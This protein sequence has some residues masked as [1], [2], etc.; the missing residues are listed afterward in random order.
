MQPLVPVLANEPSSV[1]E[2]PSLTITSPQTVS[3]S[4]EPSESQH[5]S[6]VE[7]SHAPA[8]EPTSMVTP[9]DTTEVDDTDADNSIMKDEADADT[10]VLATGTIAPPP[11]E[12]DIPELPFT[13]V[14]A[15][16]TLSEKLTDGSEAPTSTPIPE[17]AEA[18]TSSS[19]SSNGALVSDQLS[20]KSADSNAAGGASTTMDV[21]E[22]PTIQSEVPQTVDTEETKN[23]PG[24]DDN[25]SLTVGDID[26]A[27]TTDDRSTTTV[28][29]AP[30]VLVNSRNQANSDFV[31]TRSECVSVGNGSFYCSTPQEPTSVIGVD[32]VFSAS[33]ATGDREIFI[34]RA[35]VLDQLTLNELE[36][37][38]PYYDAQSNSIVFHRLLND[39]YQIFS[40]DL[41]TGDE[42]QLTFDRYNNMQP[43]RDGTGTV[44]QGWVGNDWEIML[45]ENDEVIMLTDNTVNDVSP[46]INGAYI[47]WQTFEN[48]GWKV[49]V[50][51][52]ST[53]EVEV[54]GESDGAS[55][56]NPRFV[57]VYDS[58]QDNGDIETKGYDL[59]TK[60]TVPLSAVPTSV[61]ENLPEPDQTGEN[62]ALVQP[63]IKV[64]DKGMKESDLTP[65]NTSQTSDEDLNASNTAP[66][67]IIVPSLEEGL[68]ADEHTVH[69]IPVE[70]SVSGDAEAVELSEVL[71]P[72]FELIVLPPADDTRTDHI[73]DV[74]ITPYVEAI[75]EPAV[76]EK[77]VASST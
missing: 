9:T 22:L 46:K 1:D 44:W 23:E 5:A 19:S 20:I 8:Q 25:A 26:T 51:D 4:I 68:S 14:T 75:V 50:Y 40:L 18:V 38:A 39:R 31:F 15:S 13:V 43:A 11:N 10:E 35:G 21:G 28:P 54:I 41:S 12:L 32:R 29:D 62:R 76:P 67:D 72:E 55:V 36:D 63:I 42:R 77:T 49:K 16:Q 24:Q 58:K 57:L 66:R 56:E 3:G 6:E 65:D 73:E 53:R 2:A 27:T 7:E 70:D 61:P 34:E 59:E 17:V 52:R 60:Q 74:I 33:D 69:D 64:E 45:E 37:D 30:L 71:V 47:T 48:G